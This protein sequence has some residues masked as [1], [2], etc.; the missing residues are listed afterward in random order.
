MKLKSVVIFCL[1]L[2]QI[3]CIR[4]ASLT[5]TDPEDCPKKGEL[6]CQEKNLFCCAKSEYQCCTEEEYFD[7]FPKLSDSH[8]EPR[9]IVRGLFKII[10]IIVGTAI[11]V[12]AVCCIC[13]FCCP[14]CLC[15][16]HRKGTIIRRG[17][18]QQQQQP[19]QQ[20][21]QLGQP[22]QPLYPQQQATGGYP[23]H[24]PG[25]QPVGSYPDNPPPYPGPPL[26]NP[27]PA[28]PPMTKNDY[29][30][31]PAFNPNP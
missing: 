1:I 19:G 17:A 13:C 28:L 5:T 9:S 6:E 4:S 15:A 7:Q 30:R 27:G 26:D 29:D 16:K 25:Y 22:Q 23:Q 10:A 2:L 21:Q 3:N 11:F 14:F 12:A 8:A 24:Q 18:D 31:Q 20:Q